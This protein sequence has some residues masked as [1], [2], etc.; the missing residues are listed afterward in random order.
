MREE[1]TIICRC[2]DVTLADIRTALDE[3]LT[4]FE[5]LKRMLRCTMGS[6]QGRTCREL[7]LREIAAARGVAPDEVEI[8]VYRPPTAPVRLGELA[9]AYERRGGDDGDE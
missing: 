9:E 8:P 1:D 3:G 6:C 4:D 5:E 2:E 7:I